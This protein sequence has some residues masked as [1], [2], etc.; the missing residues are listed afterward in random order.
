MSP[1]ALMRSHHGHGRMNSADP[2]RFWTLG[3]YVPHCHLWKSDPKNLESKYDIDINMMKY[4]SLIYFDLMCFLRSYNVVSRGKQSNS[5]M[6]TLKYIEHEDTSADFGFLD[7]HCHELVG[8][9]GTLLVNVSH[10][11]S[12]LT[13]CVIHVIHLSLHPSLRIYTILHIH[14]HISPGQCWSL[15][16][17]TFLP[18]DLTSRCRDLPGR[19]ALDDLWLVRCS[20]HAVAWGKRQKPW[21]TIGNHGKPRETNENHGHLLKTAQEYG[22]DAAL[23]EL[24]EPKNECVCVCFHTYIDLCKIYE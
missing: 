7:R 1:S 18:W 22:C 14:L 3:R 21:E 19:H 9:V 23:V 12:L 16:L 8:S 10:W 4:W 13:S 2:K 5:E 15:T 17:L 24:P 11:E 20:R 6:K